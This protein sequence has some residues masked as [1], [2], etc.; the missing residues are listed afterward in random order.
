MSKCCHCYQSIINVFRNTL[1]GIYTW[2]PA[3]LLHRR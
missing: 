1:I 3:Q 2:V